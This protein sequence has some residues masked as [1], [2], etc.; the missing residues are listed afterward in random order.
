MNK[1][2][3][4]RLIPEGEYR[5]ALNVT[6]SQSD[7]SDVGAVENIKSSVSID[8]G[9][10]YPVS[11]VKVIGSIFDDKTNTVYWFATNN[12][13][14]YIY[15][16]TKGNGSPSLLVSGSFLNFHED[17]LI[18]GVNILEGFLYWT[19][20]RNQPRRINIATAEANSNFYNS[21][22]LVS[23]AKY[24]PYKAPQITSMTKES[25]I[26]STEI[27]EKFVRFA[28]RYK[29]E[30]NEYSVLSPFSNVAF[31]PEDD[32]INPSDETHAFATSEIKGMIN[33]IN[34]VV[35]DIDV[36]ANLQI[37]EVE[38][39]YKESDS[40]AI[41][42]IDTKAYSEASGTP[43]KI[44]YTY[45]STKP[46]ST[47]PEDQLIRVYDNVPTKAL[48]QEII[49]N[50]LVYGNITLG[51][52][53][54]IPE[55]DYSVY[56]GP[57]E[58]STVLQ[59]HSIKQRRIYQVGLVFSDIYGRSTPVYTSANSTIYIPAK[60]SAFDNSTF[61]GDELKIF[62]SEVVPNV[63]STSNPL[64]WYSYKV[65][66]KQVEQEY[67]NVYTS[68]ALNRGLNEGRSYIELIKDN[69]NKVPRDTTNSDIQNDSIADSKIRLYPKAINI[70][71]NTRSYPNQY[72]TSNSDADLI[73]VTGIG[74]AV[75]FYLVQP[76]GSTNLV[77]NMYNSSESPLLARLG[78]DIGL[79]NTIFQN[80]LA[81]FE[82][83]PFVSS[84]DI[85]YETVTSGLVED[86]NENITLNGTDLVAW[87]I[88]NAN[89]TNLNNPIQI[90]ESTVQGS[91]IATLYAFSNTSPVEL[92]SQAVSFAI[93]GSSNDFEIGFSNNEYFL[94]T[95]QGFVYGTDP[96]D[97]TVVASFP[98]SADVS[99]TLTFDITNA[100]PTV[101]VSN[102]SY[103]IQTNQN[104]TDQLVTFTYTNGSAKLGNNYD[105][106]S[107]NVFLTDTSNAFG[108]VDNGD[109]TGY[110]RVSNT[111]NLS[112]GTTTVT[113]TVT[114]GVD[115]DTANVVFTIVAIGGVY[116]IQNQL[117]NASST[118]FSS[119]GDACNGFISGPWFDINL[120]STTSDP[121][122]ELNPGPLY[123][124]S[125]LTKYAPSGWYKDKFNGTVGKW[126]VSNN[127]GYWI[128]PPYSCGF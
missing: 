69:V 92:L 4:E 16:W 27:Q 2:L 33:G 17:N 82:T 47:L 107:G 19:D 75:D 42:I 90:N 102:S 24:A 50:R 89:A 62:F 110:I 111:S 59:N 49:S 104:T 8:A 74:K 116:Y 96:A 95:K 72:V 46:K 81:V 20:N 86:L 119:S 100:A 29:F 123:T 113:V 97:I 101:T 67:Y 61:N 35:M 108:I 43:Q 39:L 114:D 91:K 80:Q 22:L 30:D 45:K 55:I 83:E 99:N 37:K 73:S 31:V 121:L 117:A 109:G 106:G 120:Y 58:D 68:G 13:N 1:D 60:S 25:D 48:A 51:T 87:N 26:Y 44:T 9:F 28:Y 103:T 41:R 34:Q 18:T 79:Q 98:G 77:T 10:D 3:D 52:K 6:V 93:S 56:Y 124:T 85:Y 76:D 70:Y 88:D 94:K 14:H 5:D 38:I 40:A 15:K 125:G 105:L 115:S 65:V 84:L 32:I 66:I 7:G 78:T 21:D 12:T 122:N 11:G 112:A 126:Y 118:A 128:I 53:Y 64:G 71:D 54:A 57:K 36:P 63:Y 127:Q 23:V